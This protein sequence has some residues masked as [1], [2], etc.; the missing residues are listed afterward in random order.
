MAKLRQLSETPLP[1]QRRTNSSQAKDTTSATSRTI[2][3]PRSSGSEVYFG[4]GWVLQHIYLAHMLVFG[5]VLMAGF[6]KTA[7]TGGGGDPVFK[8]SA[9][10]TFE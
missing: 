5:R 6:E 10:T 3:T 8:S 4:R 7:V 9:P 2:N 1:R